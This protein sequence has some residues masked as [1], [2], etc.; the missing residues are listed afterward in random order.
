MAGAQRALGASFYSLREPFAPPLRALSRSRALLLIET[1]I[2]SASAGACNA[3][4][5]GRQSDADTAPPA[6]RRG[7][8][9]A[10]SFPSLSR[11]LLICWEPFAFRSGVG[12]SLV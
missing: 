12:Y 1:T 2:R 10:V 5:H 4:L 11:R 8:Q 3:L 7:P 6:S 9:T